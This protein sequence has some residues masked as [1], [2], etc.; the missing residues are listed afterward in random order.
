MKLFLPSNPQ[1]LHFVGIGGAGMSALAL[2]ALKRG[3][4]VTGSD[5]DTGGTGD[6]VRAGAT[7]VQG[8]A[9]DL[10]GAA[11]AVVASAAIPPHN[12]DLVRA[13][14]RG[15]PIIPRKEALAALIGSAR[16]VAIA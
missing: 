3:L 5:A 14:E 2:I 1:P 7:V 13:R 11:G 4:R 16:S 15:V 9:P 12:A 10:A 8:E 6:L